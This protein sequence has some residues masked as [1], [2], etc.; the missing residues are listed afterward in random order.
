MLFKSIELVGLGV[1]AFI[2]GGKAVG[3]LLLLVQG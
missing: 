3:N 2:K 1:D